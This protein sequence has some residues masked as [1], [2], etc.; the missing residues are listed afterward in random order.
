[1]NHAVCRRRMLPFTLSVL[2]ASALLL[3][4]MPQVRGADKAA[5]NRAVGKA[6]QYLQA[7][8]KDRTDGELSLAAYALLKGGVSPQDPTVQRALN[9]ILTQKI[10][11][12]VYKCA[13][14][15][16]GMYE[17]AL[18]AMILADIDAE[19]YQPQLKLIV[20]FYLTN[21]QEH[22]G[23]TY[24]GA[25]AVGDT[26]VTQY[27][28]LALW[29]AA[30]AGIE[31]PPEAWDKALAWHLKNQNEDGGF[32]YRPGTTEGP[33]QG[34]STI[35]M[36]AAAAGAISIA[37][38]HLYPDKMPE[39][40]ATTTIART[41]SGSGSSKKFGILERQLPSG[42]TDTPAAPTGPFKPTGSFDEMEQHMRRSVGWV[43]KNF[44]SRSTFGSNMY[45]YYCLERMAALANIQE[46]GGVD[47]YDA[48]ANAILE[49]QKPDGS[50]D[51]SQHD[52]AGGPYVVGTSFGI[53]FLTRSTAKL[54]NRLPREDGIGGG[55]L[56]GG[57]G[58][59]ENLADVTVNGGVVKADVAKGALDELLRSLEKGGAETCLTF[60]MRSSK[61]SS[62]EIAR[63]W[64]GRRNNW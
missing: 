24:Q 43:S 26:S 19:K 16:H 52:F 42:T 12:G 56:A 47:W 49:D 7:N 20:D 57:R 5:I 29:A 36:S 40:A 51:R 15:S 10:E 64:S 27:A 25:G 1:M 59:P 2:T 14:L 33:G 30:R 48:C 38:L 11:N 18:D 45:Y 28:L 53:L 22:G 6:V 23:W 58:L 21:Q 17:A 3:P 55:L 50:W 60:R 62:W 34:R 8:I 4:P 63:S 31:I 41:Q 13:N 32:G 44:T 39:L 37:A 35:N 46:L 54:L 61:P 9:A